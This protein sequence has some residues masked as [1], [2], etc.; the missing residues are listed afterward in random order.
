MTAAPQ[1]TAERLVKDER[2]GG[3]NQTI[4]RRRATDKIP[5]EK[6]RAS[7]MRAATTWA[8]LLFCL[9]NFALSFYNPIDFDPYNFLYRGW[10]WW[11]F[12]DMKKSTHVHNVALLGSSLMVSAVAGVDANYLNK[13]L[14]LSQYHKA[15]YLSDNLITRF[16][17]TFNCLNLSIPGQMPSDAY[18]TLKAMVAT[19]NRPDIVVYGV[20][21]RDFIDSTMS[22]AADTEAFRFLRRI[23]HI[24]DVA[25]HVFRTPYTRLEW[26]I[27]RTFYVSEHA[28]D[29]QLKFKEASEEIV[30]KLVV[31]P[32]TDTPFTWWNRIKLLPNY[33]PGEIRPLAVMTGPISEAEARKRWINNAPEYVERYKHP[34][35]YVYQTQFYFL[36]EIAK[37]CKKE[38]IELVLVNMP[39]TT[40]NINLLGPSRYMAYVG[41]LHVFSMKNN[42][43]FY[44]MCTPSNYSQQ[45]FHDSVHLNAYGGKKFFDQLVNIVSLSG[46]TR[47]AFALSGQDL[48]RHQAVANSKSPSV[49]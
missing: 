46:R 31:C 7:G 11:G 38:R 25:S 19:A 21:P 43:A 2:T 44:D 3:E 42:V 36:Q 4:Y 40:Y 6:P 15:K 23:V 29:F 10:T 37:F 1:G 17:G 5:P 35:K 16:G 32:K 24:D 49:Q 27:N 18:M 20:A 22:S 13:T 30:N 9:G 33:L 48:E 45:D 26:F 8:V 41:D 47:Q 28:A 14:D 34:D 12:N 39:I